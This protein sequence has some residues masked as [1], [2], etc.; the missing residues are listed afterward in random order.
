MYNPNK[1]FEISSVE[2]HDNFI[3]NNDKC[4]MF[5]GSNKCKK[6]DTMNKTLSD[7]SE[8]YPD[9]KFSRVEVTKTTV[10]NLGNS[11][12]LLVCYKNNEPISKIASINKNEIVNMINN[13]LKYTK[14]NQ[15]L[16]TIPTQQ[17]NLLLI[18]IND[19][20]NYNKFLTTNEKC[21]VFFGSQKC[22]HCR[23]I[24]P[25]IKNMVN[26]YPKIRFCHIEVTMQT[27]NLIPNQYKQS[28]LPVFLFYKNNILL[29]D[30]IGANEQAISLMIEQLLV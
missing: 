4:V 28:G 14:N 17:N 10:E 11:L 30:V 16:N 20:Y 2:D 23:N 24:T 27:A 18:E 6:C 15:I 22:P 7:L 21:V 5:F 1:I 26:Q 9:I 8:M 12:P 19:S 29:D 25:I 13:N 3:Q